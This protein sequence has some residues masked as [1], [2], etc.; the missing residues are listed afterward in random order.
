MNN[1]VQSLITLLRREFWESPVAFKWTPAGIGVLMLVLMIMMLIFVGEIDAQHA[2]T[3]D[4]IREFTKQ[5]APDRGL[6]VSAGLFSLSPLFNGVLFFVVIFYLSGSL[7]DDRKD[8]SILFWKSL[9]VS[10]SMT[11]TSKLIT[12]CIT[13]PLSFFLAL[14]VTQIIVLIIASGYAMTAGVNPFTAAWLPANLPKLFIVQALSYLVYSLWMLPIYGWLLFC[15]SWAP[16]LPIL[17]ATGVP[18]LIGLLQS[19]YSTV[20]SFSM[21]GWNLWMVIVRR[22]GEASLPMSINIDMDDMNDMENFNIE[23]QQGFD[24]LSFAALGRRMIDPDMLLGI[25]VALAFIAGAIW[26]RRRATDN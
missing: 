12:A 18:V 19:F 4:S 2:F 17:I 15:S 1:H 9:P 16:R 24:F 11:V 21:S 5:E 14:V 25:L 6:L 3:K 20:T 8:R 7:Y 26:F 22:L 23:S 10:D 13:V